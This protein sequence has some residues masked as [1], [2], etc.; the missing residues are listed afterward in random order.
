M[1]M[2][3]HFHFKDAKQLIR[4]LIHLFALQLIYRAVSEM[5]INTQ[6]RGGALMITIMMVRKANTYS[7]KPFQIYIYTKLICFNVSYQRD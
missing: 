6:L 7:I 4:D 3:A 2:V 1:G 5:Q